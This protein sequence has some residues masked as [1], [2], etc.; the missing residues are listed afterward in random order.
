M[1]TPAPAR[2][3]AY[4]ITHVDNIAAI[5]AAG[6]LHS[7]AVLT[8]VGVS[9]TTIGMLNIKKRRLRLPVTCH[10]GDV[11]G[12]Y[13]PFYFCPPSIMLFVIH[14]KNNP[15]LSYRGGQES[16]VHLEADVQE[17][18]EWAT[19]CGRR[20]AF[21]NANAGALYA[22]FFSSLADLREVN[23]PAV[24]STDFRDPEV[25][26]GKQ[27]AGVVDRSSFCG[28]QGARG[29]C[30]RPGVASAQRCHSTSLVL[31]RLAR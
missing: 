22:S 5:V 2:P 19:G 23:W 31:L 17:V 10:P 1:T 28:R 11:V 29:G 7:D 4:H 26:D 20:W 9:S 13:V 6:V 8:E 3:K 12:D 18:V 21:S 24:G 16:I 14:C 30:D 27:G 25:K 15:D